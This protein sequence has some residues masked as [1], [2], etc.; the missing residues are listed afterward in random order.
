MQA[1]KRGTSAMEEDEMV[2]TDVLVDT[3]YQQLHYR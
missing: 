3:Y 1:N 2:S